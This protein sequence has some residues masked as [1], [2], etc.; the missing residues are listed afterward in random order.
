V[1]GKNFILNKEEVFLVDKISNN[2]RIFDSDFVK[3][4]V[5]DGVI[6]RCCYFNKRVTPKSLLFKDILER[7]MRELAYKKPRIFEEMYKSLFFSTREYKM[8]KK[9]Y[10][11]FGVK[12]RV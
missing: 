7:A 9:I 3:I 11:E 10:E 1:A 4:T 2:A 5:S 8:A 12:E 6:K